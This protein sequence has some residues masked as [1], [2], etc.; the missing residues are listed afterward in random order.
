MTTRSQM[1]N[2][3]LSSISSI[4][5]KRNGSQALLKL[6]SPRRHY[7]SQGAICSST[8]SAGGKIVTVLGKGG[9]GKTLSAVA[10]AKHYSTLGQNVLL[11]VQAHDLSAEYFLDSALPST[12][13]PVAGSTNLSVCAISGAA[14]A[15]EPFKA[16]KVAE[17]LYDFSGGMLK[18]VSADELP[19]IPGLESFITLGA[20]R[21]LSTQYDVV[22]FD[23]ASNVEVL[24]MFGAP[25]RLQ[26]YMEKLQDALSGTDMGRLMTPTLV[27][28][29]TTMLEKEAASVDGKSASGGAAG[30]WS[31][32]TSMLQKAADSFT[33]PKL[34][35]AFL[36][37]SSESA[38][39]ASAAQRLWAEAMISGIHVGGVITCHS[40]TSL[41]GGT[42]EP[43]EALL[44]GIP[45]F[46]LPA[47]SGDLAAL[48]R[49]LPA[50]L[51]SQTAA[52][53]IRMPVTIDMKE[54]Q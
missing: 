36:V 38:A 28:V 20:L 15:E 39:G 54:G 18:D 21:K 46:Q 32:V 51:D 41:D 14:L 8:S 42:K 17:E 44:S 45:A 35:T 25:A 34:F 53:T 50:D 23:G 2:K 13:E 9:V 6:R 11:A 24:R 22:V 43:G 29:M 31:R 49:G 47:F 5:E 1:L 12:P 10:L 33:N 3:H 4:S 27:S 30:S 16:L 48:A 52:D 37:T 7:K 26:W 40:S 19:M